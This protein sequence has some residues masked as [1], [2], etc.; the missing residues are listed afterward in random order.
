MGLSLP[1][2]RHQAAPCTE[3]PRP[4][5][6]AGFQAA[7]NLRR[8]A[9]GIY[10]HGLKLRLE[11][12][13]ATDVLSAMKQTDLTND[14]WQHRTLAAVSS[15][16]D[17]AALADAA[18]AWRRLH[19]ARMKALCASGGRAETS[20]QTP[21]QR[22]TTRPAESTF[23]LVY[24]LRQ[25]GAGMISAAPLTAFFAGSTSAGRHACILRHTVRDYRCRTQNSHPTRL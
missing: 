25:H 24:P 21:G 7:A 10:S 2:S 20:K 12:L 23:G 19:M 18:W 15:M 11:R 17:R 4:A 16:R 13:A 6:Y 1:R 14:H 5:G 9:P 3:L 22:S 8:L